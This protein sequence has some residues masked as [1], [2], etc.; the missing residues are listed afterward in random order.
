MGS[1]SVYST[2]LYLH[3]PQISLQ[4][5]LIVASD[6]PFWMALA[7]LIASA[8]VTVALYIFLYRLTKSL[9]VALG[10][11]LALQLNPTFWFNSV[12]GFATIVALALLLVSL[13]LFQEVLESST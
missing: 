6:I 11:A 8:T 9:P 5:G 1:T 4:S 2:P 3:I 7:S 10:A 13:V 12:Y